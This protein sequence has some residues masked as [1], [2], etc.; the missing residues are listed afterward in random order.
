MAPFLALYRLADAAVLTSEAYT[1]KAG[2]MS[3]HPDFR[4][5]IS[6]WDRNLVQGPEDSG[7]PDL[8]VA[9]GAELVLIDRLTADAAPLPPEVTSLDVIGLDRTVAQRGVIAPG[10]IK[11]NK[12]AVPD[13]R[14]GWE[15]RVWQPIHALRTPV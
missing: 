5:Y 15:I 6:D 7:G 14:P 9:M 1:A 12:T 3:V 2:R 8:S 11:E 10:T 4:A 13:A